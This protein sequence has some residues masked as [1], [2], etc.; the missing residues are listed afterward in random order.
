MASIEEL[1]K[2]GYLPGGGYPWGYTC[3]NPKEKQRKNGLVISK[4]RKDPVL[5]AL[6]PVK[7]EIIKEIFNLFVYENKFV[8]EICS[9]ISS[10]FII[11]E[12][13]YYT[14]PTSKNNFIA[15]KLKNKFYAGYLKFKKK[16]YKHAYQT[17][18]DEE[19]FDKAQQRLEHLSKLPLRKK[20]PAKK[21]NNPSDY[22]LATRLFL[23]NHGKSPFSA[24]P[25]GYKSKKATIGKTRDIL[26]DKPND[27]IVKEVFFSYINLEM[28]IHRLTKYLNEKFNLNRNHTFFHNILRKKF[29]YGIIEYC[30]KEYQH[31]YPT[32]ITKEI[33]DAVQEKLGFNKGEK[34]YKST[35]K[36]Q[37]SKTIETFLTIPDGQ[38]S[39]EDLIATNPQSPVEIR[40][41]LM[42]LWKT[43]AL[44]EVAI[45]IW[46]ITR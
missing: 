28:G 30:G 17:V 3:T 14:S 45:N 18:I 20:R 11:E 34:P 10:K 12:F 38:F 35:V 5:L 41:E 39:L 37:E 40:K 9:I 27:E 8:A 32:I 15:E 25:F 29:Y 19:T 7:A 21:V 46:E 24:V 16:Y 1:L 22:R 6:D 2:K 26:L 33:Y 23:L 31:I 42:R 36:Q 44:R 13:K 43:K 4:K